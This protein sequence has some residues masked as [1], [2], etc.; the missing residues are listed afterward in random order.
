MYIISALED[1]QT[2][3]LSKFEYLNFLSRDFETSC[4][5]LNGLSNENASTQGMSTSVNNQIVHTRDE[6]LS[7]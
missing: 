2:A 5:V 6:Y 4:N 1:L 3:A 7:T